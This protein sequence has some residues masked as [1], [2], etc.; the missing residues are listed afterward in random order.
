ML[1]FELASQNLD[2]TS[3]KKT[4]KELA[5]LHPEFISLTTH[6]KNLPDLLQQLN[7]SPIPLMPHINC[8]NASKDSIKKDLQ[9]YKQLGINKL[10]VLRGDIKN[11]SILTD[12]YFAS[13]LIQ[14]IKLEFNN[15]FELTV[16]AYPESREHIDILKQKLTIGATRIITQYCY[17]LQTLKS[18]HQQLQSL[19]PSSNI[20]I[21]ILPPPENFQLLQKLTQNHGVKITNWLEQAYQNNQVE[22]AMRHFI[23]Q[24]QDLNFNLQ[25]FKLNSLDAAKISRL[26]KPRPRM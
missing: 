5:P 26:L 24:L 13:E 7:Q 25:L 1:S 9:I 8:V 2:H 20:H 11:E 17:D 22:S 23:E 10:L 4:I 18:F 12:L 15:D 16:A 14:F 19:C 3:L 6:H 21:G